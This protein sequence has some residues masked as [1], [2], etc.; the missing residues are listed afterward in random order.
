LNINENIGFS[1][2][3]MGLI[4]AAICP[5]LYWPF[6]KVVLTD[7]SSIF[8]FWVNLNVWFVSIVLHYSVI[9]IFVIWILYVIREV[10]T[11]AKKK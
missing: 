5:W 10:A 4:F 1:L 11:K 8:H 9:G 2:F 3:F 7:S 6:W